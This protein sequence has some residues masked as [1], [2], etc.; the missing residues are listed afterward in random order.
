[1]K[2]QQRTESPATGRLKLSG[3][4][5]RVLAETDLR[6]AVVGNG[7]PTMPSTLCMAH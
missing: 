4:R 1:M 6:D 3:E 5:I 2:K 7:P